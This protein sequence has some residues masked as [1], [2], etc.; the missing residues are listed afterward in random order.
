MSVNTIRVDQFLVNKLQPEIDTLNLS[1]VSMEEY[2]YS[3]KS[4]IDTRRKLNKLITIYD[5]LKEYAYGDEEVD[6]T[7]INE[8]LALV[9]SSSLSKLS[10]QS[11]IQYDRIG[12]NI[13]E[14]R[15]AHRN[16][17]VYMNSTLIQSTTLTSTTEKNVF[18][19][20]G[21]DY[22][23]EIHVIVRR[24]GFADTEYSGLYYCMIP[25]I[26]LNDTSGIE[27]EVKVYSDRNLII[28]ETLVY[29]VL[30]NACDATAYHFG[31]TIERFSISDTILNEST[32][33]T[34]DPNS[35]SLATIVTL[36]Y[37]W[38]INDFDTGTAR[39]FTTDTVQTIT[40][41]AGDAHALILVP[42]SLEVTDIAE[43]V[44]GIPVEMEEGVHYAS[45][46]LRSALRRYNCIYFRDLTATTFQDRTIQFN[47]KE[48]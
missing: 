46:P 41:N 36:N 12:L 35:G 4:I 30:Y 27:F 34:R 7:I 11:V 22:A 17:R 2:G 29:T 15:N 1:L 16:L 5:F 33:I 44:V 18:G 24:S 19:I 48:V 40:I 20:Y 32:D 14:S 13:N 21:P 47:I 25:D 37:D 45:F 43:L 3:N 42:T 28:E 31:A 26:I 39:I 10:S 8:I 23:T 9:G 38:F 6:D